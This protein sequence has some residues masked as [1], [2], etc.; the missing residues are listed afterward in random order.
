MKNKELLNRISKIKSDILRNIFTK[1]YSEMNYRQRQ[2]LAKIVGSFEDD[3]KNDLNFK[4]KA[5]AAYVRM[6]ME[7]FHHE[8][9]SDKQMKELNPIIRNAIYTFLVD[10][11]DSD[12]MDISFVC[13]YNLPSYWEDCEYIKNTK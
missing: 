7:D 9:L 2:K 6:N 3:L 1:S 8:H 12:T 11:N 5:I 13:K 10:E 4:A